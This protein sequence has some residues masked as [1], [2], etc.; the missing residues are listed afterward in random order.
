MYLKYKKFKTILEPK[1]Q[2]FLLAFAL[3]A[4]VFS[5][6]IWQNFAS[7]NDYRLQTTFENN[8]KDLVGNIS[9]RMGRY[10][11]GLRGVRGAVVVAGMPKY[12][13]ELFLKYTA[14]R[15]VD[16]EFPG[17]RGFGLIYKVEPAD[18]PAFEASMSAEYGAPKPIKFLTPNDE[19]RFVIRYVEPLDRNEQA[20]GLDIASE[21]NRRDAALRSAATGKATLTGPI[22]IVQAKEHQSSSFLLLIPVYKPD[23]STS[24]GLERQSAV[25]GWAYSVLTFSEIVEGLGASRKHVALSIRDVTDDP[26]AD[27]FFST[28]EWLQSAGGI[29]VR[30]K[31]GQYGRQWEITARQLPSLI[32]EAKPYN[33][34]LIGFLLFLSSASLFLAIFYILLAKNRASHE[35][36]EQLALAGI[37][38]EASSVGKLLVNGEGQIVRVNRSLKEM[39]GYQENELIGQTVEK[40]VPEQLKAIH[41]EHRQ[42]YQG[43]HF[44]IGNTGGI[45]G[46]RADGTEFEVEIIVTS[47]EFNGESYL[48][49]G[50]TDITDRLGALN[51]LKESEASWSGLANSLPQLIW[52]CNTA[53]H[54]DFLSE[55]WGVEHLLSTTENYGAVFYDCI[56]PVDR[57]DVQDRLRIAVDAGETLHTECRICVN[58]AA[59][60]WFDMQLM[61]LRN[62][63]GKIT[64]WIGSNTNIEARKQAEAKILEMYS[65]LELTVQDRTRELAFAKQNLN[66]I[67]NAV[68]TKIGYWNKN[69]KCEFANQPLLDLLDTL[70]TGI[71]DANGR[72]VF[73]SLFGI[74]GA[75]VQAAFSGQTTRFE[76]EL[77][78]E[79]GNPVFLDI[80]YIPRME[81]GSVLGFYVLMQDVTEI[82]RAQLSA[83]LASRQK[84]AFLAVMSHEIRTPLNG[85]LGYASLLSEKVKDPALQADIKILLQNAQTLTAILNDILDISKVESGH[86]KLEKIPF[87][88]KEQLDM[89]G[90]LHG[91]PAHEKGLQ[92]E[93]QYKGIDEKTSILGDPTRLR[94]VVHNL[95]SNAIKFTS[96]GTVQLKAELSPK[97]NGLALRMQVSDSGVGIPVENQE[98][99]FRPFYQGNSST[100]RNFGGSGLGLSVIKSIVDLMQG[101]ISLTSKE[102]EGTVFDIV[103]PVE[104]SDSEPSGYMAEIKPIS[105]KRILI[106]DDMALNLMVLRKL[107]EHDHHHVEQARDGYAAA[108]MAE[109][110][111]YD[112]IFMDI[113][114]PL[115]DGYDTARLIRKS[116]G[117]N[118]ETP[119]VALTG[120]AFADDVQMALE[121]GMNSHL[122]KPVEV[123]KV[124]RCMREMLM[125]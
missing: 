45:K 117:P 109:E 124:R 15:E 86:F 30:E 57:L 50:I 115:I 36:R 62:Q 3:V 56:A 34:P 82:R 125:S 54:I 87:L 67:L 100:F 38:I 1:D 58:G 37:I 51:K 26:N 99:L 80:H 103:V 64:K 35:Q 31:I 33:L 39:F 44:Q 25:Q 98:G 5:A 105:E 102:G 20:V 76:Q 77:L 121:S 12:S 49:G 46:L 94:Q 89:C 65:Q 27:V 107:L 78:A 7:R 93:V 70:T 4:V 84:S 108:K 21:Q 120:N 9:L 60:A 32:E 24:T 68:P 13:R 55:Q 41:R 48:L 92:F 47:L 14:T 66:N 69:L 53:G 22:T 90:T 104:L 95:L 40:L 88:L 59:P 83:E 23:S 16:R 2:L 101:E 112:L 17:A 43:Q 119:I 52:T 75:H 11:Y 10:E 122:S 29:V 63:A 85:I 28:D 81:I 113:S 61:P 118:A 6:F 74:N 18:S 97:A 91:I 72:P 79:V 71:P 111:Q 42:D 8:A 114:M 96:R 116:T 19:T 123:E 73:D 110:T 106:V